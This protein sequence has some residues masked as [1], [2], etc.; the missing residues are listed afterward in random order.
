MCSELADCF[1]KDLFAD[2]YFD[3]SIGGFIYIIPN[4]FYYYMHDNF[5][6]VKYPNRVL[7]KYFPHRWIG[8]FI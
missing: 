2:F 4:I 1:D 3:V 7:L 5:L 8:I 6:F